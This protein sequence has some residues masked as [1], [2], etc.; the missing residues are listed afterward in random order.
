MS[1]DYHSILRRARKEFPQAE[2]LKIEPDETKDYQ[3]KYLLVYNLVIVASAVLLAWQ[4]SIWAL[5]MMLF[6][7]TTETEYTIEIETGEKK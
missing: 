5:L 4:V 6:L 7:G 3:V 1:E 2:T